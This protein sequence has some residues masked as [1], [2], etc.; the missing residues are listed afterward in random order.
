MNAFELVRE[1]KLIR[2]VLRRARI[3]S[4][5]VGLNRAQKAKVLINI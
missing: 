1:K 5:E 4:S 3:G 2:Q